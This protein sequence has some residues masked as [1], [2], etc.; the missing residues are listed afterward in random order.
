MNYKKCEGLTTMKYLLRLA[1]VLLASA[2]CLNCQP[3]WA[4]SSSAVT[5]VTAAFEDTNLTGKDFSGQNLQMAKFTNVNLNEANFEGSDLRGAVFNGAAVTGAKF[6]GADLSNGLVYLT[7]FRGT[8]LTDAILTEAILLRSVFEGSDVT[9]AD[10]SFA[11]LDDNQID[12]L[13]QTAS[14][15]N[16]KTGI[17]TRD[18][19][20]CS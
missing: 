5:G 7:S 19:L 10:F 4:A 8:D 17:S 16:S 6:H 14:G 13:C 20:G 2:L 3:A 1:I 11:V 18:S 9:G 12:K 15:T